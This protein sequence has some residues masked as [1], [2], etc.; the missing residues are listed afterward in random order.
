MAGIEGAGMM[1]P[2]EL[3]AALEAGATSGG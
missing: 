3:V 2:G 1:G